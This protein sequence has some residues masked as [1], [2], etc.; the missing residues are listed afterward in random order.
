MEKSRQAALVE[1]AIK[2]SK[3]EVQFELDCAAYFVREEQNAAMDNLILPTEDLQ[4]IT[5]LAR[6]H[7]NAN[8]QFA[9]FIDKKS[10]GMVLLLH[11]GNLHFSA[12]I[13]LPFSLGSPVTGK[14][15]TVECVAEFTGRPLITLGVADI[16]TEEENM[17]QSSHKMGSNSPY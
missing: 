1:E 8:L 10:E 13:I 4:L 11:G 16:G 9:G 2:R 15:F 7:L 14:T 6:N 12:L 17:V 5:A 3:R